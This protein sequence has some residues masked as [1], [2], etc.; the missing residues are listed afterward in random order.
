MSAKKKPTQ[1]RL[2]AGDNPQIPKG[3]GDGPVRNYIAAIPGWKQDVARRLDELIV[4]AVPR[5]GKAVKYN[6]PLY[7]VEDERWFVSLHCFTN[8][9]K[10]AFFRGTSLDP[11]PPGASKTE[12][13]RYL[14]VHE[15]DELDEE[16]LISWF[17]QASELPG[18][19]L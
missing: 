14:D 18:E 7:G 5:V 6:S 13:T 16:R 11:M 12:G 9:V 2:L 3:Y 15:D 10:V 1:P 19:K 4:R 17:R 8:Y